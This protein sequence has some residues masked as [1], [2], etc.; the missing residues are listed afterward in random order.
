MSNKMTRKDWE[1]L[2]P[3][4]TLF[5]I[6]QVMAKAEQTTDAEKNPTLPGNPAAKKTIGEILKVV[7]AEYMQHELERPDARIQADGTMRIKDTTTYRT[8]DTNW[9]RL[10]AK[11][12]DLEIGQLTKQ[13]VK[14]F[15]F[16][17]MQIAKATHAK[18]RKSREEKGLS[19]KEENGHQAYN[20]ALDTVATIVRHAL[21][22]GYI[23]ISPLVGIKRKPLSEG[24]RHGLS[25]EQI[26]ELFHVVLNGGNDPAL[27][28]LIIWS[29][30]E[31]ACRSGGIL[32]MCLGDIDIE[33]QTVRVREKGGKSR[34]Q[35]VTL[36]LAQT[37]DAFARAR[38]AK[39]ST[40]PVFFFHQKGPGQGRPLSRGRY[41]TLWKRISKEL[42]WV[43]EKR[44]SNHWIRHTTLS[45]LDRAGTPETVVSKY[46]GHGSAN[47]TQR[48]TK[49]RLEEISK[50]HE[51]LFGKAHPLA[52]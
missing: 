3:E 29:I 1:E 10:E 41:E 31:L 15:C 7:R 17:A 49:V 40:D 43:S 42:S 24:D 16:D 21:E 36:E 8:Y 34:K 51:R 4:L 14:D 2:F 20:R 44:V 37:L 11:Y 22:N 38:G 45:W 19:V 12:E 46:A 52:E 32:H 18:N 26:E 6:A 27:D 9:K 33:H 13:I 35:P 48:Y 25:Q 23:S 50:A 39:L 5:E 28:Y 30:L 47:V